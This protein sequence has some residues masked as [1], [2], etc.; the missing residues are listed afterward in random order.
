VVS[1]PHPGTTILTQGA[2]PKFEPVAGKTF[3]VP[4]GQYQIISGINDV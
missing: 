4:Q 1:I 3:G 2:S